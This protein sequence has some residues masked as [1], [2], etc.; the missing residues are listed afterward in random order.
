MTRRVRGDGTDIRRNRA[1]PISGDVLVSCSNGNS[2][3]DFARDGSPPA[4]RWPFAPAG[5]D[6]T[7]TTFYDAC[8]GKSEQHTF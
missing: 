5:S 2:S 3:F 7:G 8:Y 6:G 4:T 1:Q